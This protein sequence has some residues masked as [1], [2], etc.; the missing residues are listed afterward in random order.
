MSVGVTH[1]HTSH[2]MQANNKP[3][4]VE[5][6][7]KKLEERMLI[8]DYKTLK[9]FSTALTYK[10]TVRAIMLRGPPG[11][12]KTSLA[13][14]ISEIF[15]ADFLVYQCT[16]GTSE[17]DLLY[18][19]SPSERTVSG[20]EVVKGILPR[21]LEK[22]KQK[23][24]VV[25]LDEFDKTRPSADALL[26]DFLQNA[27][28]T[29]RL[30]NEEEVIVGNK[31]NLIV[32]LTSNDEREFSEPLMRRLVTINL[33]PL[34]TMT[35]YNLL[36]KK[37]DE[38]IATLLAQIYD[39]T[40]NTGLR[41]PAT[42][43]ELYQLGEAIS[44][45]K[46]I[47]NDTFQMLLRSY[48]IKYDD[49]FNK[50]IEY[51][52]SRTPYQW[53]ESERSDDDED[54]ARY[55]RAEKGVVQIEQKNRVDEEKHKENILSKIP[56]IELKVPSFED[57][58]KTDLQMDVIEDHGV[59][60]SNV[61]YYDAV[62]KVLRPEPTDNPAFLSDATFYRDYALLRQIILDDLREIAS[63]SSLSEKF[64]TLLTNSQLFI[65][66]DADYINHKDVVHIATTY[67]MTIAYYTKNLIRLKSKWID[68]ALIYKDDGTRIEIV[69][70]TSNNSCYK[71]EEDLLK[72]VDVFI[73]KQA[74]YKE[75]KLLARE[76]ENKI[77]E[78]YDKYNQGQRY[79][80]WMTD[81]KDFEKEFEEIISS[82]IE[83]SA[84]VKKLLT[85]I[86]IHVGELSLDSHRNKTE[87]FLNEIVNNIVNKFGIKTN[88]SVHIDPYSNNVYLCLW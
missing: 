11:V 77:G 2:K 6:L 13:E 8:Y 74:T 59:I 64:R 80:N 9:V 71:C 3:D 48:V 51:I 83:R 58:E 46:N 78:L 20:I 37:F 17:D 55:Y 14:A 29:V 49:D 81:N 45:L 36:L 72:L 62:I 53:I 84:K 21:A 73:T 18:K 63:S 69:T 23:L 50:Y 38:K 27:R 87:V 60:P 85:P 57:I 33:L 54:I 28:V 40:I 52:K 24:V 42:I 26:L 16:L 15:G 47:D 86:K 35:V 79:I 5:F 56:K 44:M 68:M 10:G 70:N 67:D 19:L 4:F 1:K 39:D 25:L 76:V 75:L 34:P 61:E 30:S 31:E 7:K 88:V 41:K 65:A 32:F 12:G 22:S 43:Q 66:I 82:I